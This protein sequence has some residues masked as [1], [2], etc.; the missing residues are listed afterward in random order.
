MKWMMLVCVL[1]SV[2]IISNEKELPK[3]PLS[4]EFNTKTY[5]NILGMPGFSDD[6]LNMHFTLYAGYVRNTCLLEKEITALQNN[7]PI[8]SVLY[9]ALKRRLA[10]EFNGMRLHEMYFENLGGIG[11][12]ALAPD[13]LVL[14]KQQFGSY[15]SWKK[16][17]MATGLIRGIGWVILCRDNAT[18]KLLNIWINEHDVGQLGSSSLLLVMDVWEHA[19]IT[20]YGL[21]RGKYIQA[22][23]AN[24]DWGVVG[25]RERLK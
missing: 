13:L 1:Y 4:I 3:I 10:W 7:T 6:L 23:F 24:I 8:N 22:F 15:E 5:K 11:D 9:G 25:K 14:L 21:D 19:Y 2:S 17:F 20:E 18:G 12:P 16:D